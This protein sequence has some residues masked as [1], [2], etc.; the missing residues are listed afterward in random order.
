[1]AA[2]AVVAAAGI[3]GLPAAAAAV[4]MMAVMEAI[5]ATTALTDR[6]LGNSPEVT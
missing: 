3:M 5:M 1:M 2:A 6:G 4:E